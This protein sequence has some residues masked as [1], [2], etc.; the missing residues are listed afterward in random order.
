V[1]RLKAR[2]ASLRDKLRDQSIDI[3]SFDPELADP[4]QPHVM[5]PPTWVSAGRPV[6]AD[7]P[8]LRVSIAWWPD[9]LSRVLQLD[10]LGP[11][12]ARL[13]LKAPAACTLDLRGTAFAF[14][15]LNATDSTANVSLVR[16]PASTA[17]GG[18]TGPE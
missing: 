13:A 15:V 12:I 11:V 9:T 7:D 5:L 6:R 1:R 18:R 4:S 2:I 14:E 10:T 8:P 16:L 17:R 3:A